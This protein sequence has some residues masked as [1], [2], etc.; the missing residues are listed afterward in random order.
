MGDFPR[1]G[2][3]PKGGS[4][5]FNDSAGGGPAAFK[6][7]SLRNVALGPTSMTVPSPPGRGWTDGPLPAG[8][9]RPDQRRRA[10]WWPFRILTVGRCRPRRRKA[11]TGN[12]RRRV[13]FLAG[14]ILALFSRSAPDGLRLRPAGPP[15]TA[16]AAV[17]QNPTPPNGD[18]TTILRLRYG[19]LNNLRWGERNPSGPGATWPCNAGVRQRGPYVVRGAAAPRPGEPPARG[20]FRA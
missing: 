3:A 15:A 13:G 18:S 10:G 16:A 17:L 11:R 6:V 4:G 7:P 9:I 12:L 8:V 5:R 2:D 14:V 19:L 1:T 20:G